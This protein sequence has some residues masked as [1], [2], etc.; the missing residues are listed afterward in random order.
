[1]SF[2]SIRD[3]DAPPPADRLALKIDVDTL[4]GAQVGVPALVELLQRLG[5][6]ATFLVALGPDRTG[7]SLRRIAGAGGGRGRVRALERYGFAGLWHGTLLPAPVVG[8]KAEA[9]IRHAAEAG[10]EI[11]LRS[12]SRHA[13]VSHLH[14][15]TPEWVR[16]EMQHACDRFVQ[17]FGKDPRVH[18]ACDWQMNRH[19]F[20]LTQ[21]LGFDYCSDTR[22]VRPFVPI[23]DAEIVACPQIPTT[24][25]TFDELLVDPQTTRDNVDIRMLNAIDACVPEGHVL[26]LSA[27]CDGVALLPAVTRLLER[28]AAQGKRLLSLAEYIAAAGTTDLPRHRVEDGALPGHPQPLTMQFKEFLA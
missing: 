9:A 26:S 10:F 7:R 1:M 19:A 3:D 8:I 14:R 6:H 12:W 2:A 4:R 27:D 13:W 25:P 15:S 24:L 5:A 16:D 23:I 11:G 17:I 22:G 21:R 28:L 18:G 20:R